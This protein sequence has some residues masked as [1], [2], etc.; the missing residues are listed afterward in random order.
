MEDLDNVCHC[1]VAVDE[2]GD[3]EDFDDDEDGKNDDD[4]DDDDKGVNDKDGDNDDDCDNEGVKS[5][6]MRKP[7]DCLLEC[8]QVLGR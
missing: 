2:E 4:G 7:G 1:N 5:E 3:N 8:S 6:Q